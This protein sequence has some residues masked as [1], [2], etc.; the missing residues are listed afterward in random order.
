MFLGR[1]DQPIRPASGFDGLAVH[2]EH[3]ACK[4]GQITNQSKS[5]HD[6]SCPQLTKLQDPG[7][8]VRSDEF[9]ER[10][11]IQA[12]IGMGDIVSRQH[13]HSGQTS[14]AA[15]LQQRQPAAV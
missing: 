11:F 9:E 2:R 7:F 1:A 12:A 14:H 4:A 8:L 5:E 10:A 6:R 3:T 13:E 15:L